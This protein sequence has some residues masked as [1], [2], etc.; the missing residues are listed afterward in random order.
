MTQKYAL[1]FDTESNGFLEDATILWTFCAK[2][3]RTKQRWAFGGPEGVYADR[4]LIQQLLLNSD[5]IVCHNQIKH[6][7][8]LLNKLKIAG[9]QH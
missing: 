7:L 4:A 9:K 1:A 5:M 6:D 8:P 2:D 3:M